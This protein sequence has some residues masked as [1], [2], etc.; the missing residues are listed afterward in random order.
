[1]YLR[2]FGLTQ[3][4]FTIAPDPRFLYLSE[5]HREALAHLLYGVQ[6]G[7]FVLLTGEVG[8]GKTTVCRCLL[9]QL[10]PDTDV[11]LVLNP[12]VNP[13]ELIA[14]V[15]DELHVAYADG[16]RSV[17]TLVDRLNR[18]LLD[19]NARG[20]RTVVLIDEAQNL[21]PEAL[22]QMRLLTNLETNER[23]LLQII[24]VG[25]PEL[26][27]MLATPHL[28]Q[29]AQRITARYHLCAL[30]PADVAAYVAHRLL[31]AGATS[32]PFDHRLLR[33][34]HA[35]SGG[36][37]RLVNTICDRALLGAYVQGLA[38]VDRRTLDRAAAE[39]L[40]QAAPRRAALAW[41]VAGLVV[42][43]AA[44]GGYYGLRLAPPLAATAPAA[45]PP[46]ALEPVPATVAV[47]SEP[48]PA[49]D[50][51]VPEVPPGTTSGPGSMPT[52]T[53][54]PAPTETPPSPAQAGSSASRE[55]DP[56]RGLDWPAAQPAEAGLALAFTALL[57]RWGVSYD[58]E[59]DGKACPHAERH[60]LRC[61]LQE[62][63]L[64]TLRALDRP[65]V[66]ALR[67]PRAGP[68]QAA[69]LEIEGEQAT[70]ALADERRSV[71]VSELEGRWAGEY[72]VLWRP[73]PGYLGPTTRAGSP[74]LTEWL[75]RRL[76]QALGGREL[77]PGGLSHAVV[78][79]QGSQGLNPDGIV[80]PYTL[81]R[82]TNVL[83]EGPRLAH[84]PP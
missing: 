14:T 2:H 24:M 59:H 71:P 47:V 6:T 72:V 54:A 18:H 56:P 7:G 16:E 75:E 73:P 46:P 34:V 69:L 51:P 38:R 40:G 62:G 17:K 22:E 3:G 33:R 15:C 44:V 66:V 49:E 9:E 31:V 19:A 64:Q 83:G 27:E 5:Q 80:G 4:P 61:L 20:R 58:G 39:V 63:D 10:P 70:L 43:G 23:K 79:F 52:A 45:G 25:Q 12:R 35:L 36:I 32:Q 82:L 1:V 68:V 11:A 29:L 57:A 50:R 74:A 48:R 65:A 81:I 67:D 41:L 30:S 21:S 8:T 53:Q 78:A 55:P 76:A 42:T 60:G 84:A 26:R 37:P 28:R 13:L 77:A